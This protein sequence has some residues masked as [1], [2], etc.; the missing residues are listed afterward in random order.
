VNRHGYLLILCVAILFFL[1]LLMVFN[2]T[3]AEVLESFDQK[4][5]HYPVLKQMLHA[6]I[7]FGLSYS[8]YRIGYH[9]ILLYIPYV[10]WANCLVLLLVFIPH[11]GQELNGARR[12]IG[13]GGVSLQP[14]ELMKMVM[15]LYYLAVFTRFYKSLVLKSFLK[16]LAVLTIPI[17]L[18]LF[19]PDNG[20]AAI[21][22]VTLVVLF[23][24]T[25]VKWVYWG[26]PLMIIIGVSGICSSKM[27]HVAT[28]I[29]IYLDPES[30][31]LGKGHQPY[32]AKVATGSGGVYGR[33]LGES[34]QKL[35]YLPEARSDY[36]AAIYA[37]ELGFIGMTFMIILYMSIG[38]FGF[39][40]ASQACDKQGLYVAGI[41]T[42]IICFQAFL[43][44]GVVSGLLP[45][46]GTNLP[47]F[48][49]GG[50]SL[51]ANLLMLSCILNVGKVAYQRRYAIG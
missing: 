41:L 17:L 42:F 46:K 26:M 47:F 20:T 30:D 45:S 19:E 10:F 37:E 13:V 2:T 18:I 14:S 35:H 21:M 38:F 29:R 5:S 23:Y 31:H 27:P 6:I 43:N 33:G 9:K 1:G 49:H 28:R 32:Q 15:P 12:W 40:I 51:I 25:K 44:L 50:S 22:L 3:S 8:I 34:L 36:I 7:G 11:L 24:L 48:S 39:K 16:I 4:K